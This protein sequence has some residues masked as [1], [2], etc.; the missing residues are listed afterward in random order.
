MLINIL[1]VY[2]YH[3]IFDIVSKNKIFDCEFFLFVDVNVSFRLFL[4]GYRCEP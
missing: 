4:L 2:V 1:S 3:H